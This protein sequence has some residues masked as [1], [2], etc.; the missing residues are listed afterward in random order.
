MGSGSDNHL[1][2]DLPASVAELA[3]DGLLVFRENR[4]EEKKS[5]IKTKVHTSCNRPSSSQSCKKTF[6]MVPF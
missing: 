6:A 2:L 3:G 1:R 4:R 5:A